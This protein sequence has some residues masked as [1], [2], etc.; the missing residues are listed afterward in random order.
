MA[1]E[2]AGGWVDA[3]RSFK[4]TYSAWLT[5]VKGDGAK[6]RWFSSTTK[7]YFTIDFNAQLFFYAHSESDKTVSHP[8]RFKDIVAADQLPISDSK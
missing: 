1:Y 4:G 3:R 2:D 8:I 7:R 5:K 6:A